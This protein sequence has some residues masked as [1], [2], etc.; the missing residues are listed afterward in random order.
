M[1]KNGIY[2]PISKHIDY[3]CHFFHKQSRS[4][5]VVFL[6]FLFFFLPLLRA[7]CLW[8]LYALSVTRVYFLNFLIHHRQKI[9]SQMGQRSESCR[10]AQNIPSWKGLRESLTPIPINL[11]LYINVQWSNL[12]FAMNQYYWF[13]CFYYPCP[14]FLFL[15]IFRNS[16]F[17]FKWFS[18]QLCASPLWVCTQVCSDC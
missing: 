11:M 18:I 10:E 7:I 16:C 5:T 15:T 2:L 14:F 3:F 13:S 8:H 6:F 4:L 12:M 17:L 1:L 9:L